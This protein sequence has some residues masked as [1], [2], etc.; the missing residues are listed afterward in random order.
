MCTEWR[1]LVCERDSATLDERSL[2]VAV[3]DKW[4]E[5]CADECADE[6]RDECGVCVGCA[7]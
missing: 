7:E 2:S 3:C 5:E 1:L 6:C 4:R